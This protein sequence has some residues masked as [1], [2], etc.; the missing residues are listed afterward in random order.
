MSI[1]KK[2]ANF[3]FAAEDLTAYDGAISTAHTKMSSLPEEDAAVVKHLAKIGNK[4][5]SFAREALS[6]AKQHSGLMPRDLDLLNLERTLDNRD[7]FRDR[8]AVAKHLV[9]RLEAAIV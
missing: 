5:E 2:Y 6:F 9:E 4:S 1:R 7:T 3:S 8:L